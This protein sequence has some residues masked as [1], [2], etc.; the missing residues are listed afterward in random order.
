MLDKD[1]FGRNMRPDV[2]VA[3]GGGA[4]IPPAALIICKK[5]LN[6]KEESDPRGNRFRSVTS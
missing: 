4:A 3:S 1:W 5:Y 6:L 2:L